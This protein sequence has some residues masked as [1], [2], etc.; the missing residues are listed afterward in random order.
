MP[1]NAGSASSTFTFEPSRRHT[2]PSS[3]PMTP[4]PTP[5]GAS[6]TEP[7]A[8]APSLSQI[9]LL[10]T[11]TPGSCR[12]LDPVATI[13][14]FASTLSVFFPSETSIF[15]V[16]PPEASL[17]CPCSQVTLFFLN[18]PAIPEV[19]LPTILSLRSSIVLRSNLTPEAG[20]PC[21]LARRVLALRRLPFLDARGREPEL[22]RADRGDVA[23][24]PGSDHHHVEALRHVRSPAPAAR[25][26][27]APPRPP[28]TKAHPRAP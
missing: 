14:F 15:H 22:R 13:T 19:I 10:S 27:S 9:T 23:G 4:A 26:R 20:M 8:S 21:A 25:G 24:G 1:R 5:P 6:G 18:R 11:G 3:S 12:A 7:K 28:R 17:P 16:V 2:L